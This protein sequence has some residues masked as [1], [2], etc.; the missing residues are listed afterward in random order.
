MRGEYLKLYSYSHS[1]EAPI[2]GLRLVKLLTNK[3][4]FVKDKKEVLM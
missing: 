4:I 1:N 2:L 3:N